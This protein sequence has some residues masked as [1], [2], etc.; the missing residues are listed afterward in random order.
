MLP[1]F[2][3]LYKLKKNC[4]LGTVI[5]FT[6]KKDSCVV[7][8]YI[9]LRICSSSTPRFLFSP[10]ILLFELKQSSGQPEVILVL[11]TVWMCQRQTGNRNFIISFTF[12]R[13]WTS[14]SFE[15]F[16]FP[17]GSIFI[18]FFF[19]K[20]TVKRVENS[21]LNSMVGTLLYASETQ[22]ILQHPQLNSRP[23]SRV[24]RKNFPE[25]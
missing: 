4:R 10:L 14:S 23:L 6:A 12:G 9:Y 2:R 1:V 11:Y 21:N 15:H 18:T 25:S 20:E 5:V 17:T 8:F 22:T 13:K 7:G 3:L 16:V 19:P 24:C